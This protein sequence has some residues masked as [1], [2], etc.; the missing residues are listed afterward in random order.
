MIEKPEPSFDI[1]DRAAAELRS[2][3]VPPGP[4]PELLDSLLRMAKEIPSG[5]PDSSAI[6]A[7]PP[8]EAIGMDTHASRACGTPIDKLSGLPGH[9]FDRSAYHQPLSQIQKIRNTIMTRPF[10]SVAAFAACCLILIAAY[11]AVG[12]LMHESVAFAEVAAIIQNAKTMVCTGRLTITP[13]MPGMPNEEN[14]KTMSLDNGR[15][16]QEI[17]KQ[18]TIMDMRLGKTLTLNPETKSAILATIKGMPQNAMQQDWLAALKKMAQNPQAEFLGL[19]RIDGREAKGFRVKNDAFSSYTLWVDPKS[20]DPITVEFEQQL[21][22]LL[23]KELSKLADEEVPKLE[24]L[25]KKN[26]KTAEALKKMSP[27]ASSAFKKE[28]Q[29]EADAVNKKRQQ[30]ISQR[31]S[32]FYKI[33]QGKITIKMV[34]S[35]FQFDVPLDDSL[36]SLT[37]PEG[38]KLQEMNMDYSGGGIK[39]VI[40]VLRRAAEMDNGDFPD[41]ITGMALMMK[42]MM[43]PS[44]KMSFEIAAQAVTTERKNPSPPQV[45]PEMLK[46]QSEIASLVG[47]MN[48]FLQKNVGWKYAGKGVK[49]GDAQ[50]PIFWYIPKDSKQGRIVY[51]D[52]SVRNVPVDQLPPDP[53]TKKTDA[54]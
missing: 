50:T 25:L 18:I 28:I 1:V 53:K 12:P 22:D 52:L 15:T 9:T 39:D 49:R 10:R 36:F 47:R 48:L 38:Y 20:G 27:D 44:M 24:E 23:S 6:G 13:P 3:P 21:P 54:K 30:L 17:G 19:K 41:S 43:K 42:L 7:A 16:R 14:V 4:P 32:S 33:R 5:S 29:K 34:L 31:M 35:D 46:Q 11:L 51:G 8:Q 2:L 37:P 45:P 26:P 40:E